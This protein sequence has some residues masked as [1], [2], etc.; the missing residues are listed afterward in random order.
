TAGKDVPVPSLSYKLSDTIRT[1]ISWHHHF[2]YSPH[3]AHCQILA[4]RKNT[5]TM[6]TLHGTIRL[7]HCTIFLEVYLLW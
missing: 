7:Q 4:S 2:F 5:V 1:I 6:L 3:Q